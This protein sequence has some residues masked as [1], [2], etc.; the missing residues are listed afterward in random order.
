[1]IPVESVNQLCEVGGNGEV[2][3]HEK[4]HLFPTKAVH[5]NYMLEFLEK[6]LSKSYPVEQ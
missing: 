6:S 3:V 4:G 2:V 5:V 1:M